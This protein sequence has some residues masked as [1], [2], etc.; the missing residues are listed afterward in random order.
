MDFIAT[1][2]I[3][4]QKHLEEVWGFK[5]IENVEAQAAIRFV[6]PK[7]AHVDPELDQELWEA[8][9]RYRQISPRM[10]FPEILKKLRVSQ[11]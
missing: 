6:D 3:K 2:G 7:I 8:F 5:Q 11:Q 10:A 9:C 4:A 1:L